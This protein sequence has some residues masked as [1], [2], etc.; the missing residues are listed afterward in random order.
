MW[1]SNSSATASLPPLPTHAQKTLM[2]SLLRRNRISTTASHSLHPLENPNHDPNTTPHETTTTT[3]SSLVRP[4]SCSIRAILTRFFLVL[5]T[6]LVL[7]LCLL[8]LA[9]PPSRSTTRFFAQEKRTLL[10]LDESRR[11]PITN[12]DDNNIDTGINTDAAIAAGAGGGATI[13]DITL[14]PFGNVFVAANFFN[15]ENV[16]IYLLP[17]ILR[18]VKLLHISKKHNVFVSLQENGSNDRTSVMMLE[19]EKELGNVLVFGFGFDFLF[20]SLSVSLSLSLWS[21]T[22]FFSPSPFFCF[23]F[24]RKIKYSTFHCYVRKWLACVLQG[25]WNLE[26]TWWCKTTSVHGRKWQHICFNFELV[27]FCFFSQN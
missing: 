4:F 1:F 19:F 22:L 24:H 14:T 15:S 16:L 8:A 26:V 12:N 3:R 11:H 6:L 17:E 21:L 5:L 13:N 18:F 23:S 20:L 2:S 25:E 10:R 27:I 7:W 9:K